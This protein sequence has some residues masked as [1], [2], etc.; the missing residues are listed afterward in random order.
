MT[1]IVP[2]GLPSAA[3]LAEAG[4]TLLAASLRIRLQKFQRVADW[5]IADGKGL[6]SLNL[7]EVAQIRQAVL[8][9]CRRVPWRALCMEQAVTA[10]RMIARRG[11]IVELYYGVSLREHEVK[12]HVWCKSGNLEVTGCEVADEYVS[13]MR[14]P[15]EGL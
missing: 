7:A 10:A 11:H 8:V 3:L 9:W 12:A 6:V 2:A 15:R 1:A 14:F 5:A 4:A 13:L